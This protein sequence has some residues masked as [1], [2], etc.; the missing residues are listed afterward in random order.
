MLAALKPKE[1]AY[2]FGAGA[3]AGRYIEVMLRDSKRNEIA[4][5]QK[6]MQESGQLF[7]EHFPALEF[8][9]GT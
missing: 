3:G 6:L 4:E 5:G 2:K 9:S 1:R 8:K 7:R